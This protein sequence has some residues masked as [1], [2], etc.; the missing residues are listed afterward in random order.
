MTDSDPLSSMAALCAI[1]ATPNRV[2]DFL[3]KVVA[4][5]WVAFHV[6][7]NILHRYNI[8]IPWA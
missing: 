8:E 2:A 3:A 1:G 5:G 7:M 6:K 4:S